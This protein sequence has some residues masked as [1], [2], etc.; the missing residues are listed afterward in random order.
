MAAG[1]DIPSDVNADF[2]AHAESYSRFAG[3]MK[4]GAII[5]LIIALFVVF[6]L[7]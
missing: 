3:L 5:C 7:L 1:N 2:T 6:V 4:W